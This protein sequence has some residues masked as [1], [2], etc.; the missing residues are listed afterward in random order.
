[1]TVSAATRLVTSRLWSTMMSEPQS[2]ALALTMEGVSK[3]FGATQALD[4]VS[5]EIGAGEIHAL[6]GENGA[7]K[8]TLVKILSGLTRPDAG[9]I[10]LFGAPA[11]IAGA[12]AAHAFGL[13]TAFQEISLVPDLTVADNLLLPEA[14]THLGFVLDRRRAAEWVDGILTRL[15]LLDLDPRIDI[16]DCALPTRQ[17]LEI[18]RAISREPRILLLDEPTSALSAR[19]V[20]WLGRRIAE[21]RERGTTVVLITHRVPEVRRFCDRLTILRNGRHVGSFAVPDISDQEVVR[22]VIGRSLAATFPKRQSQLPLRSGTPVLSVRGMRIK[23]HLDDMS[24]E[25]WPGEILGIAGLQGMGQ[26]EL[27]YALFGMTPTDG[28]TIE[29]RGEIAALASPRDAIDAGIG[30]SLVPEDRKTE[31]LALKLNG[32]ENV[33]LPVITRFARFGWLDLVRERRAVDR[34]LERV[35]VHPRALYRACSTFS[36]GN[37]QKIAIA[38]WLLA[39]SRILLLFDPTRGV[40]VGT[41]HEI[42]LLMREF[43]DAGGAILFYSTDVL[44]IVNLCDR[45]VVMYSG[46]KR[47]ELVGEE[48]AEETIMRI[49]L[50]GEAE[51][52]PLEGGMVA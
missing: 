1:M 44:E 46:R 7:G 37:Q 38:K 10:S 4:G 28:G 29:V 50:G 30:I 5:F 15:E 9:T 45:V 43:A 21:L 33:S 13:R 3:R 20:E 32:R 42:Y 51:V 12:R 22:L 48:I 31:A 8:S 35:Q 27:F 6:L 49:A 47:A 41:K 19:D 39:E 18:A 25:L 23:G 16:R 24:L 26:N 52:S 2:P 14:P 11:D 17:K 36:G 40:D 34:I